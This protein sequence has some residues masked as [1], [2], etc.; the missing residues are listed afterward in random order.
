MRDGGLPTGLGCVQWPSAVVVSHQKKK[1]KKMC[2]LY[3]LVELLL[4]FILNLILLEY[5]YS[6]VSFRCAARSISHAYKYIHSIF[7]YRL[8]QTI[9]QIFVCFAVGFCESS[10]LYRSVYVLFP[11]SQFFPPPSVLPMVTI[12]LVLKSA[13]SFLFYKYVLLYH[14]YQTPCISDIVCYLFLSD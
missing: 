11:P 8:L 13:S 3:I 7:P 14:F 10:V 2:D 6:V 9:E 1:K 5:S 12:R 4:Y